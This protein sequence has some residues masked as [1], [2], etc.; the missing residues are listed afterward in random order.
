ML[1]ILRQCHTVRKDF[2]HH[3][4]N[5]KTLVST[6]KFGGNIIN[7]FGGEQNPARFENP[8]VSIW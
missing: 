8:E 6:G 7:L 1:R 5:T 4:V 2:P 3:V